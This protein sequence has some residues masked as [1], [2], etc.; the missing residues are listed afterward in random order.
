MPSSV[1][2]NPNRNPNP[3]P[4]LLPNR[5]AEVSELL[6]D[7]VER[8]R[9]LVEQE[10]AK[11][12]QGYCFAWFRA[13]ARERTSMDLRIWKGITTT[14]QR[15]RGKYGS[16]SSPFQSRFGAQRIMLHHSDRL[17]EPC[18]GQLIRSNK[19]KFVGSNYVHV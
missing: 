4:T 13:T 3:N 17:F 16:S 12:G 11:L 14:V 1:E 5:F 7:E 15:Q 19:T 6:W 2:P 18:F 9:H 8:Q 10:Y